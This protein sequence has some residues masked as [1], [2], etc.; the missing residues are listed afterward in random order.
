MNKGKIVFIPRIESVVNLE[1]LYGH[2]EIQGN[3]DVVLVNSQ[4]NVK[5]GDN[6]S[7]IISNKGNSLIYLNENGLIDKYN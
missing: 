3:G 2:L 7:S 1:G 4:N 6:I 5:I